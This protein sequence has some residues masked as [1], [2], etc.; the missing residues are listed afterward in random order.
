MAV[1]KVL[2]TLKGL[3]VRDGKILL[4]RKKPTEHHK[5]GMYDLPGGHVC[6]GEDIAGCLQRT[7]KA[8]V[9]LLVE[10]KQP[11]NAWTVVKDNRVELVGTTFLCG[12]RSGQVKLRPEYESYEWVPI[13]GL[14]KS[15]YPD[16]VKD[17]VH[18]IK[19]SKKK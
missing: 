10:I 9:N 2:P 6:F 8:D 1:H 15:K 13:K 17:N 5:E 7:I 16:W 19:T 11:I 18:K 4:L 3:I 12:Y 14:D